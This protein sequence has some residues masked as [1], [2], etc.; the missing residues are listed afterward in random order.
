[1]AAQAS[2]FFIHPF[3]LNTVSQATGGNLQLT[4]QL[5]CVT[6]GTPCRDIGHKV[7]PTQPLPREAEEFPRGDK[8]LKH[9]PLSI[10]LAY[11]PLKGVTW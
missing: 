9:V 11:F 8:Y 7:L 1:M 2:S 3:Y 4:L 5:L 10:Y 6:Y